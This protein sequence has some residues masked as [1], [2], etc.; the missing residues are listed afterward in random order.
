MIRA[1][2]ILLALVASSCAPRLDYARLESH[3][4]AGQCDLATGYIEEAQRSYGSNARLLYYLDAGSANLSCGRYDESVRHFAEADKLAE[5]LWTRSVTREA[6]SFVINDWTIQYGG[7]DFERALIPLFSATAYAARGEIDEALVEVRKLNVFLNNLGDTYGH[8][9]VY[10]EDAFGR[11]L[12][13][14]LYE[15]AGELD[16]AY[17]DYFAAYRAYADYR[18][19]YGTPPPRALRGALARVASRTGRT[20]ELGK[21]L[22]REG[23]AVPDYDGGEA[24]GMLVV[25][26]LVGEAP[27]KVDDTHVIPS[28]MGPI[29]ISFPRFRP[30]PPACRSGEVLIEGEGFALEPAENITAIALKDLDD[31]RARVVAKVLARAVIKQGTIAAATSAIED[32][33]LRRMAQ[34]GLNILN[35]AVER[36]DTRSWRTLPAEIH[37]AVIPLPEGEHR[38]AYRRCGRDGGAEDVSIRT[39]ETRFI[40]HTS[41]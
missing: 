6:A 9:N 29:T 1:G 33:R 31:R 11:F 40:V 18:A 36:A 26:D 32:P 25:I 8:R 22:G 15:A 16:D 17:I 12:G 10:K 24:G 38:I 4:G 27:V 3:L 39:G 20:E 28:A 30:R 2:L 7:E 34:V 19:N 13:G 5:E 21:E 35:M 37:L 41:R 14:L 23:D